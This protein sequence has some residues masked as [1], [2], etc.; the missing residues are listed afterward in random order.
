[1]P[2]CRAYRISIAPVLHQKRP[3]WTMTN[4]IEIGRKCR[5]FNEALRFPA[6]HNGL[7]AG[8]SPAGPTSKS[9]A[10]NFSVRPQSSIRLR[11]KRLN[12]RWTSNFFYRD[13]ASLRFYTAKTH[14]GHADCARHMAL[15]YNDSSKR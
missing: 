11:A 2:C 10:V 12:Q 14:F 1:V 7:V 9:M 13:C 3:H 5:R 6:A 4:A 15:A 8:S